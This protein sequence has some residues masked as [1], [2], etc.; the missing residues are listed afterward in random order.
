MS[1]LSN[2]QGRGY[3][4]ACIHE[5]FLFINKIRP[6]M[7]KKN[8]SLES[9]EKAYNS[10]SKSQKEDYRKSAKAMIPTICE[11]EP[12]ITE[13]DGD[14]LELFIQQDEEG[15]KGD[16]RDI[17]ILRSELKWEVGL[18]IKHN[19]FAVK[20]SRLSPTIDF[21]K[22]WFGY[23]CSNKFWDEVRPIFNTL[24]KA[25][26]KG[27]K[28]CEIANKEENIYEP[29]IHAFINEVKLQ[30]KS[31]PDIPAKMVEYLLSKYD[32]YKVVSLDDKK[33]TQIQTYNL[34]KTLNKSAKKRKPSLIIPVVSLPT[35]IIKI[36]FF[37]NRT[38]TA[39]LYLNNGWYFTFR[40]HNAETYAVPSLKFD[41]QLKGMPIEVLTINC[42]WK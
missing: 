21:A 18:S 10:L 17:I 32:F 30:Y 28:F 14:I 42:I 29:I 9:A 38:N 2:N 40:I 22:K 27:K 8:S 1:K 36:D 16:V 34:H 4:Y 26:Q 19:H 41:I 11:C 24:E 31:H 15:E 23:P 6:A 37:P 13:N 39:E 33:I 3:E 5:L 35:S 25:K 7:I 20:H 12:R